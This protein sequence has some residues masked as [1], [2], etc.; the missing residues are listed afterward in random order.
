MVG[1]STPGTPGHTKVHCNERAFVFQL[2]FFD[3][4]LCVGGLQVL[5]FY[6]FF[7]FSRMS[8]AFNGQTLCLFDTIIGCPYKRKKGKGLQP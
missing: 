2:Y 3:V 4:I 6:F 1:V 8:L 7:N 5:H